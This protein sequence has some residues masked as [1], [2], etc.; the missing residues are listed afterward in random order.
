MPCV[1]YVFLPHCS[2]KEGDR[3]LKVGVVNQKLDE[4]CKA[5]FKDKHRVLQWLIRSASPLQMKWIVEI[6]LT[7]T[8]RVGFFVPSPQGITVPLN[9]D[10]PPGLSPLATALPEQ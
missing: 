5:D 3:E 9:L 10:M 4:L 1:Q 8:M 2:K 7:K 6:I